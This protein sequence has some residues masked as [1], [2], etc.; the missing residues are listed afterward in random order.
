VAIPNF[1]AGEHRE[2]Y[3]AGWRAGRR[4]AA[5]APLPDDVARDVVLILDAAETT[6]KL[7]AA[8]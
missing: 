4:A 1:I 3:I 6:A 2:D 7:T 8:P 5:V